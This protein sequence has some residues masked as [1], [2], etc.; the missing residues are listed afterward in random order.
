MQA[1]NL[2]LI[3]RR[4]TN[5]VAMPGGPPGAA[6]PEPFAKKYFFADFVHGWIKV[7]DPDDPANAHDFAGNL[8]RPVDLRFSKDG[9]LYVLLRNAWV[10][11]DKFEE[12]TGSLMRISYRGQAN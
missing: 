11:D 7:I 8:R 1:R 10:V 4:K 5:S 12:G 2:F 3:Q 6:W 9:D